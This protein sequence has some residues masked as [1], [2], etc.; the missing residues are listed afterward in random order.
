[1][2]LGAMAFAGLIVAIILIVGTITIINK[3]AH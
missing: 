3:F 1:M 2:S